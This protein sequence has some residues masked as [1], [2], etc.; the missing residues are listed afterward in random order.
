MG[1]FLA[2]EHGIRT[3]TGRRARAA[4][5]ASTAFIGAFGLLLIWAVQRY[6]Y[7]LNVM[8]SVS[9]DAAIERAGLSLKILALVMGGLAIGTSWYTVRSCNR[10]L[11]HRQLP[12]PG[13]WVLGRPTV[14]SGTRAVVWGHAG[15]VLAGLLAVLG[16]VFTYM[17]WQFVD[18]MMSGV[19]PA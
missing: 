11:K 8:A 18:L 16:V 3:F 6:L 12:P 15:Q 13:A 2:E 10:V 17:L 4:F 9:P 7:S 1:S 14:L 5:F 19:G